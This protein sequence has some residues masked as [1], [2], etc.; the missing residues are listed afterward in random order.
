MRKVVMC[1]GHPASCRCKVDLDASAVGWV[2]SLW[3]SKKGRKHDELQ[4]TLRRGDEVLDTLHGRCACTHLCKQ[5]TL[6]SGRA[7]TLAR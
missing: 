2:A 4:G 6:P 3:K 1:K 7:C 5:L